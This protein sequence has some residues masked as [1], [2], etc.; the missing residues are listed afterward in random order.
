MTETLFLSSMIFITGI[1]ITIALCNINDTLKE[2][3]KYYERGDNKNRRGMDGE[4]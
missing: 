1:F 3:K 4:I 2:I